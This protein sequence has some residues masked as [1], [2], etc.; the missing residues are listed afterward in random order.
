MRVMNVLTRVLLIPALLAAPACAVAPH[1]IALPVDGGSL[2]VDD[3]GRGGVPIVFVHGNGGSAEQWRAQLDYFRGHGRRAIAIDLPGFGR[4]TAPAGGDLSLGGQ[5]A[6]VDRAVSAIGVNRFVIVGHSYGGAV[7]A[8]YAAAHPEKVAGVVYL[9]AAAT[10]LPLTKEQ[11]DQLGAAIR[12]NKMGVVRTWFAPMLKPSAES[13]QQQVLASVEKTSTDA[14]LAAL[15]SL[16]SYDAKA[17]VDAYTGPR[18]VIAASDIETP[19]AFQLQFPH[20]P[21]EKIGGAGHWLM[22]DKPAEVN[23]ILDRFVSGVQ[24]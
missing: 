15:M 24:R 5:S 9:D 17:L 16:T 13:V 14:F 6:A 22:L 4:S 1:P 21:A 18:L 7:V 3:G 19:A 20:I 2:Y 12:A 11:G 8:S 23:A 10:A